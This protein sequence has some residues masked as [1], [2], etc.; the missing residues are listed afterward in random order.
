AWWKSQIKP[1]I[2]ASRNRGS[3]HPAEDDDS[4]VTVCATTG[5]VVVAVAVAACSRGQNRSPN[6]AGNAVRIEEASRCRRLLSPPI[7]IPS[8]R[9]LRPRKLITM[10]AAKAIRLEAI[11]DRKPQCELMAEVTVPSD[12]PNRL[13]QICFPVLSKDEFG[14]AMPL[15]AFAQERSPAGTRS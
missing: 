10:G 8:S 12:V 11:P 4:R 14:S 13:E 5:R 1:G 3:S 6:V 9:T 15:A 7:V 2:S